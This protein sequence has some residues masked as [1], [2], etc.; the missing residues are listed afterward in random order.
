MAKTIGLRELR[1]HTGSIVGDLKGITSITDRGKVVAYLVPAESSE[2]VSSDLAALAT[3]APKSAAILALVAG[4][5]MSGGTAEFL[6]DQRR[7]DRE[8]ERNWD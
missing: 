8:S 1:H 3:V 5:P 6:D 7:Q 4:G 2:G